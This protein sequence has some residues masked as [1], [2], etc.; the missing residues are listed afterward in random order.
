MNPGAKLVANLPSPPNIFCPLA[1]H[2]GFEMAYL[3]T[4]L[5]FFNW[6]AGLL[7]AW[8]VASCGCGGD[9]V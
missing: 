9:A 8:P 2:Y 5:V 6:P 3:P 1:A 7:S 4:Y